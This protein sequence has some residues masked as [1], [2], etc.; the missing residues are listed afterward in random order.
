MEFDVNRRGHWRW[1]T[2][3]VCY[4][5]PQELVSPWWTKDGIH[6]VLVSAL[7]FVRH[8]WSTRRASGLMQVTPKSS[9]SEDSVQH[10]VAPWMKGGLCVVHRSL[11]QCRALT[12]RPENLLQRP[13]RRK[14]RLV[15]RNTTHETFNSMA[16]LP[17]W[18][19]V[20]LM[21]LMV[22]T[23]LP[24]F[25]FL[26][27]V[28]RTVDTKALLNCKTVHN[29]LTGVQLICLTVTAASEWLC[30]HCAN[31]DLQLL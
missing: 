23:L 17:G 11:F 8:G 26:S 6:W 30:V 7:S 28:T 2:D 9:L 18:L 12:H 15:N 16:S 1:R 22:D 25:V 10:G 4:D 24:V 14:K 21:Y 13:Q 20:Y 29:I 31:D 27:F 5:C 3:V 19:A